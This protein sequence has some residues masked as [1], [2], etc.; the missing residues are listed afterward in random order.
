M[1]VF[2]KYGLN[3]EDAINL[4]DN[5]YSIRITVYY[6]NNDGFFSHCYNEK[7]FDQLEV[8]IFQKIVRGILKRF[9]V[10]LN[11]LIFEVV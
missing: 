11:D 1:G 3:L 8:L 6:N 5:G 7:D 4:F 9:N 10:K 2:M